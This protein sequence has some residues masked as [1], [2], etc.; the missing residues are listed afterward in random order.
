MS[1]ALLRWGVFI[2]LCL[3]AP[4]AVAGDAKP[5]RSEAKGSRLVRLKNGQLLHTDAADAYR[6]MKAE[7]RSKNIYLWV[8]S[9]YR[10]PAKQ[11]R[12]YERYR[13]GKGPQAARPGRSNH[14]RGLAVDLV[15]GGVKTPTYDWLVSNACR[16][17]FKRTV[18]SEPWHWEYRPHSTREPKPGRDCV[19]RPLKRQRPQSPPVAS[20]EKS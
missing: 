13:K 3:F 2:L 15:I 14:Q 8:H 11:R 4:Q 9:G 18:R 5:R 10:S 20:T 6:R 12:L 16:F 17:G 19:G 1:L 7:A